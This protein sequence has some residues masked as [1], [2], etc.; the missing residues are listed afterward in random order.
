[1]QCRVED[2]DLAEE[3][4]DQEG[5]AGGVGGGGQQVRHPGGEGEHRCGDE[6]EEDVL[7]VQADQLYLHPNHGVVALLRPGLCRGL[8]IVN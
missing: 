4:G 3:G 5:G 6:V 8:F 2:A 1:M 7:P